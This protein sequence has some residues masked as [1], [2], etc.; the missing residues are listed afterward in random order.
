MKVAFTLSLLLILF[1]NGIQANVELILNSTDSKVYATGCLKY[2][3]FSVYFPYPCQDLTIKLFGVSGSP[4]LFVSKTKEMPT[5]YDITWS[6]GDEESL[7]IHHFDPES[8]PGYYYI[9]VYNPCR[10]G[11]NKTATY[12]IMTN[13]SRLSSFDQTDL[14]INPASSLNQRL[15]A[16]EY[17]VSNTIM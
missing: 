8:S 2:S 16:N 3:Y 1:F 12:S 13:T 11:F 6:C 7:T 4:Q 5:I 17:S 15:K 9:A 14:L 10:N